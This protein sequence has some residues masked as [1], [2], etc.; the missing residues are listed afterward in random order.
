[1][2]DA[3]KPWEPDPSKL[4][5]SWTSMFESQARQTASRPAQPGPAPAEAFDDTDIADDATPEYRPWILQRGQ[6][7]SAMMLALRWFDA[8][9]GMWHG[10]AVAYPSLYAID[11]IG[12]RMMSLDFGARQFVVEGSGLDELGRYLLQGTVLKI[13]EYAAPVWPTRAAGP[14]VTAIR[15]V[16]PEEAR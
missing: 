11:T 3:R 15:R 5:N 2:S 7:R 10:S 12:E 6:S 13:I 9:A 1:M 4:G 16:L 14:V 8:K